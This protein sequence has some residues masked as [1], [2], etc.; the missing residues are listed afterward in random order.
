VMK[1]MGSAIGHGRPGLLTVNEVAEELAISRTKVFDLLA[2]GEIRGLKIGRARRVS[3]SE[4][5]R[6]ITD[7]TAAS[8]PHR[9][10]S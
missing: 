2:R 10:K 8:S 7:A 1:S 4:L 3:R 9:L 5:E 6:F